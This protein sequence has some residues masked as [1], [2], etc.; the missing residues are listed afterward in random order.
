MDS[1][2]DKCRLDDDNRYFPRWEV[3]N[4]VTYKHES[5]INFHEGVS[6]DISN[7]GVCLRT[8][9][10]IQPQEKLFMTIELSDGISIQAQGRALWEKVG[11]KDFLV[12]VRFEDISE[13]VQEMI[14]NCAFECQKGQFQEKWYE[15]V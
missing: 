4:K 10:K 13:K 2:Q 1:K 5:G 15:G 14:F 6:R 8:Y 7:T 12:G 9:E 11:E 3:S